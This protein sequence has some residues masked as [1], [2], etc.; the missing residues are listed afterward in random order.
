MCDSV[1]ESVVA[2]KRCSKCGIEKPLTEFSKAKNGKN[3][4]QS[5]C[6]ECDAK[7]A[8]A[9]HEKN[10]A[11]EVIDIPEF[12][13]CPG[14]KTEKPNSFFYKR[15]SKE[16]GLDYYCKDC[17]VKAS[18]AYY[19]KNKARGS[20]AIPESKTC[21]GC[22]IEKPGSSYSKASGNKDTL[23]SCC[24][25][26]EYVRSRKRL[27][28]A[29]PE[30]IKATLESQG[31]ACAICRFIPGA[32]DQRLDL[33]HWHGFGPRGF[34]HSNC[35][36]GLGHFKD[37]ILILGKAVEYLNSPTTGILYNKHLDK[38]IR[39]RILAG[40][41]Y[42]CKICSIDLHNKKACVDHDHLTNM[43]RGI[44]CDNCNCG[45][46]QFDDSI[47]LLQNAINYL[48]KYEEVLLCK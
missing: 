35:N 42:M 24:K 2:L 43:I 22:E 1:A 32:V 20:I 11:R 36:R 29:S 27:Y 46:G 12:K 44:L 26:C 45:L 31:G 15:T 37:D 21:P 33:D 18:K 38:A 13:T 4:L 23:A 8:K 30:W 9:L 14:C 10:K 6:K 28:G 25:E 40:Q 5:S 3:G 41:N 16:D 47:E 7:K 48:K 34:L 19:E 39:K 17:T